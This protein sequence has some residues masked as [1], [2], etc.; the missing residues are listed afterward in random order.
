MSLCLSEV[1]VS[2]GEMGSP[3]LWLELPPPP[4]PPPRAQL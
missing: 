1:Q 2:L 3:T 4:P